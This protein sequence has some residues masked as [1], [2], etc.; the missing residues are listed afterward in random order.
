MARRPH[1]RQD[2]SHELHATAAGA[3]PPVTRRRTSPPHDHWLQPR[4]PP[5]V[6]SPP[7]GRRAPKN[8]PLPTPTP[9]LNAEG[10]V[11][12]PGFRRSGTAGRLRLLGGGAARRRRGQ[13]LAQRLDLV[14]EL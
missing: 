10:P 3:P 14:A 12:R 4:C 9:P 6:P 8:S 2:P 13:L 7:R 11:P 5:A 1:L